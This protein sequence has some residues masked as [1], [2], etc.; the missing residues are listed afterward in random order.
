M[1]WRGQRLGI[2]DGRGHAHQLR[3][4]WGHI[5]AVGVLAYTG[6]VRVSKKT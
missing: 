2:G 3:C 5:C 6:S 1:A 4:P